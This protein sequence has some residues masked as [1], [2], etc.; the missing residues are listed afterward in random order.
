[1]A[2]CMDRKIER[3]KAQLNEYRAR[4][5]QRFREI[6]DT[7]PATAKALEDAAIVADANRETYCGAVYQRWVEGSIRFAMDQ[8][9]KL[10]LI[11][12]ETHDLWVDFLG[13]IQDDATPLL[14]EPKPTK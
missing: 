13:Y 5:I 6:P 9:C 1:M 8:E 4:A 7:D 2:Q 14:P 11:D 12:R 10:R 3:A